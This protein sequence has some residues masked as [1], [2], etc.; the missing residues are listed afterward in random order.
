MRRM[1][2]RYKVKADRALENERYIT[3][4]FEQ[5]KRENPSGLR[6]AVFKLD[7]GV[8]FVHIVSLEAADGSHPLNNLSAFKTFTAEIQDR[9]EEPP[10]A[11][12]LN[13]IGSYALFGA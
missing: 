5:L 3:G 8:S 1:M 2:I 13:E 7:D 12:D 6:Y 9:C 10:V 11:A 4:V